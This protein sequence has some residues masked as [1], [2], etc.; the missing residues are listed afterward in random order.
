MAVSV[1]CMAIY[2]PLPRFKGR[3][4]KLCVLTRWDFNFCVHSSPLRGLRD[5]ST[6]KAEKKR[7]ARRLP[8][9]QQRRQKNLHQPTERHARRQADRPIHVFHFRWTAKVIIPGRQTQRQE[10][11]RP[12][13]QRAF[14]RSSS[15]PWQEE[16]SW[17][18]WPSLWHD[19]E[20]LPCRKYPA[21]HWWTHTE[22]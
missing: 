8:A 9:K 2:W 12:D 19:T 11:S 17:S 18:H 22:P 13:T 10:T 15:I 7:Q 20:A 14:K 5:W 3:T 16:K 4:F 6:R 1:A 21:G